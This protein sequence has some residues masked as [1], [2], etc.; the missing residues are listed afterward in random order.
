MPMRSI[1]EQSRRLVG[2]RSGYGGAG[3]PSEE[4]LDRRG[5]EEPITQIEP[6]A[7]TDFDRPWVDPTATCSGADEQG[8]LELR[9]MPTAA[10]QDVPVAPKNDDLVYARASMYDNRRATER[11]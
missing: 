10:H 6:H 3:G 4:R 5:D 9:E 8:A 1:Q 7:E 2:L 11:G